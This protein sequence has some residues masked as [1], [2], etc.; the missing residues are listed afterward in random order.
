V[1]SRLGVV[2]IG[3]RE[4]KAETYDSAQYARLV[5]Y[6]L[7]QYLQSVA[8]GSRE[9]NGNY[10][11]TQI[12][13]YIKFAVDTLE[14]GANLAKSIMGV[15]NGWREF[16][17]AKAEAAA[18]EARIAEEA[19]RAEEERIA[20]E[21]AAAEERL[22]NQEAAG[23]TGD[24]DF[25]VDD[26]PTNPE[27][28]E[29]NRNNWAEGMATQLGDKA[30]EE[31]GETLEKGESSTYQF[32]SDLLRNQDIE[33]G[34]EKVP[35]PSDEGASAVSDAAA[36]GKKGSDAFARFYTGN[37]SETFDSLSD[38][39]KREILILE[40]LCNQLTLIAAQT[41]GYGAIFGGEAGA[42]PPVT[43]GAAGNYSGKIN[44]TKDPDTGNFTLIG[45]GTEN[46]IVVS[47]NK[48]GRT[49]MLDPARS[50]QTYQTKFTVSQAE[51]N[52]LSSLNWTGVGKKNRTDDYRLKIE[53]PS[54]SSTL[55]FNKKK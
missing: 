13:D 52:R 20:A 29:E 48:S 49:T 15:A 33:L 22:R 45:S 16:L 35:T 19:V 17:K 9:V 34:G 3:G 21:T 2:S 42:S 24:V 55:N 4:I 6:A 44:V 12:G 27:V 54:L 8:A 7:G 26:I 18:E 32:R 43:V 5:V 50:Q 41:C 37:D 11:D 39:Q 1:G 25:G 14:S 36:C 51:L 31:L 38:A 46:Y 53:D 28:I 10:S 23:I 40:G 30:T 47:N